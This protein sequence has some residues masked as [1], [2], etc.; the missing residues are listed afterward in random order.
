MAPETSSRVR[1]QAPILK[2]LCKANPRQARAI[3]NTADN[4]LLNTLCECSL[5]VL[6]GRIPVTPHQ[7][8]KLR[9]FKNQ[10]H[11]LASKKVSLPR[12]KKLLQKGGFLSALLSPIAGILTNLLGV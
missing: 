11:T 5:N 6:Q 10:L 3:I 2:Y 4:E 1:K 12:K 8:Q 7:K 9:R